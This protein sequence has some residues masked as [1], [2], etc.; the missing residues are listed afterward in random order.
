V[1]IE[2]NAAKR[3][4]AVRLAEDHGDEFVQGD[5][6]PELRTAGFVGVDSLVDQGEQGSGELIGCLLDANDVLVVGIQSLLY[7]L[8]KQISGHRFR[9]SP[10]ALDGKKN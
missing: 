9:L 8:S 1:E 10:P 4:W 7:L 2:V 5:T 3:P 6:M